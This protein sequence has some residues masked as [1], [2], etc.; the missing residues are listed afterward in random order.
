RARMEQLTRN[1]AELHRRLVTAR[2]RDAEWRR[3]RLAEVARALNAVSPL[4]VLKRGYAILFDESG[5]VLRS[6]TGVHADER[7]RAR[8]VDGE[9][10]LKVE[11]A[12]TQR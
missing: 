11:H 7:L 8:L 10:R 9:L 5:R 4:D 1:M 12:D 6:A 2:A 3:L